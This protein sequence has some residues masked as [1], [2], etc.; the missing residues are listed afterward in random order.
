MKSLLAAAVLLSSTAASA[1][2]LE[3]YNG[4]LF[5]AAQVNGQAT[6]ALLDSAAEASL[7]D[8]AFAVKAKL[9]EGAEQEIRGSG[10]KA[11]ARIVEGVTIAALGLELHPEAVVVTDLGEL[12]TRLI[13]RPTEVVVGRE[14]FDAARLRI[15]VAHRRIEIA[16]KK[17]PPGKR[18]PLTRHAGVE[19]I[20]ILANGQAAQAEFDLGNG[21]GVMISRARV[22]RLH[23]KTIGQERGG[24]I[25]GAIDR[26]IV[27]LNDITVAGTHFRNV[28]AAI[29]DQSNANDLNIGTS[30]LKHFLITTDFHERAVWL[31]P[32]GR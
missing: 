23:L 12:S 5:I 1:D 21:S 20:P 16:R 3:I 18:L 4:R 17:D 2:P 6:K 8:T 28:R 14:L 25:G 15:D 7:V 9:P 26:E 11:K 22:R 10:G 13:K 32:F 30:I 27:L 31:K 29:D 24:G 19:A